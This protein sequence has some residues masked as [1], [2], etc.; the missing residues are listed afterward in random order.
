MF[1][2][3]IEDHREE[4]IQ[5]LQKLLQ[6]PSVK[7]PAVAGN[8]FGPEVGMALEYVLKLAADRGFEVKNVDGYAGHVEF[9]DGEEYI[10]V[11]S[12]LDVVPEGTGWTRPPY[13]AEIHDGMIYARGAMDDKGP[14]MSALWAL[15]AL[16]ELGFTPRRKIRIIFGLDEESDWECMDYYFK[17]EKSPL[18]GFTPDADF[19]LIYAE[20]GVCSVRIDIPADEESLNP[21]VIHFQGGHR[22]NMVPDYASVVV[23]CHSETAAQEW[24]HKLLKEAKVRQ[25]EA[26]VTV[27]GSQVHLNVHGHSAHGSTPHKGVNAITLLATLL[28]THPIS[29]ASMW[30]FVASQDTEGKSLGIAGSDEITGD[31]T[32]NLGCASLINGVYRLVFNIRYPIDWSVEDVVN[33]C[34]EYISDKWSV[35]LVHNLN[36]LYVPLE[37]SVVRVLSDV[38]Q[39]EVGDEPKALAIGGAT[40]ARAIPN[41]V[42]FGPQFPGDPDMAHQA[43]ECWGLDDYFRCIQIYA[44]AML[45]LANTL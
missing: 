21:Q 15:F 37:S 12:H 41:A 2:L 7:A 35:T 26:D 10:A 40:Y 45:E 30:R 5:S 42:A 32:S 8:P 36:P 25:I 28:G 31:L 6:I 43:D 29:N 39:R 4:I 44:H 24:E 34:R 23:D 14:G 9:G 18:G 3:F 38:Y 1:K 22:D 17:H 33:K 20:K 13:G 27:Q 19:P 16:K 11:L